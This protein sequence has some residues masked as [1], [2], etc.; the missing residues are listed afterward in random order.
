MAG[1]T[2]STGDFVTAVRAGMPANADI[3]VVAIST[4][5]VLHL[6]RSIFMRA[7][8]DDRRAF[9]TAPYSRCVCSTGSMTG[10]ALQLAVTERAGWI[11][12]NCMPGF[13]YCQG[14]GIIV[15]GEAGICAFS[16]VRNSGVA[17]RLGQRGRRQ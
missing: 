11:S 5:P 13:E 8:I 7:E 16:A 15:T 17:G 3:V 1:M 12:R 14:L 2:V 9:L 6:E 10:F 4:H